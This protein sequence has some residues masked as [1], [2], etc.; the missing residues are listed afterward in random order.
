MV[1]K[2]A[3]RCI[4]VGILALFTASVFD[5]ID[6]TRL[7]RLSDPVLTWA[8]LLFLTTGFFL[9][10]G[11]LLRQKMLK[12][13]LGHS[14]P[15]L[16]Y[17]MALLFAGLSGLSVLTRLFSIEIRNCGAETVVSAVVVLLFVLILPLMSIHVESEVGHWKAG[18]FRLPEDLY[19][20]YKYHRW[21][22]IPAIFTTLGCPYK[23]SFCNA[24]HQGSYGL[25]SIETIYRE[26]ESASSKVVALCD[27]T[28]GLNREHSL[29]VF[30]ALAPLRKDILLETTLQKLGDPEFLNMLEKGCVKVVFVGIENLTQPLTKHGRA[31]S[32]VITATSEVINNLHDRGIQ[33]VGSFIFGMD[34]D[35]ADSFETAFRFY[36]D[37]E[38]DILFSGVLVPY[39]NTP[40]YDEF[41]SAGR[42]VDCDWS[43][44][45]Y[46][47]VVFRPLR[48]T[49][50]QLI[51][52]YTS[53]Y[54]K[55]TS[56]EFIFG[57]SLKILR[58]HG[59]ASVAGG[60]FILHVF[61]LYD[62]HR[63]KAAIFRNAGR[64]PSDIRAQPL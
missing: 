43:H 35:G 21:P 17:V 54:T 20:T 47:S 26:V 19:T 15:W 57:K 60:M 1:T 42:I 64:I 18:R 61:N 31:V 50:D 4:L 58:R 28:F 63:K 51:R 9:I 62:A 7:S 36:R 55:I 53:F 27:A 44:H 39:P 29:A 24:F 59:P 52:G 32:D 30:E 41:R 33:V 11:V 45:D 14:V 22:Q 40:L 12:R 16:T 49:M 25:R 46:R 56:P 5:S 37:S 34:M 23:C 13:G 8:A 48:M 6:R 38:L 10:W 3:Y 2:Y